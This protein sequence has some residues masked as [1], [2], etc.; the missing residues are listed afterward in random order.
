MSSP[1]NFSGAFE[2]EILLKIAFFNIR[3][4]KLTRSFKFW[5]DWLYYMS[6]DFQLF[7]IV[8]R[9]LQNSSPLNAAPPLDDKKKKP[10]LRVY[11]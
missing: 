11:E 5:S 4:L 10:L 3:I 2:L 6:E 8:W 1:P 7:S 9:T